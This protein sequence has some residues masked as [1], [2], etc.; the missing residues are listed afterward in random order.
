MEQISMGFVG[1]PIA[2]FWSR[3]CARGGSVDRGGLASP[4][5]R[6]AAIMSNRARFLWAW[7]LATLLATSAA[8]NPFVRM[9][10]NV[11]QGPRARNAVFIE[12]FDDRPLTRDNFLQYVNGGHYDG[13]LMH[14]LSR[15]F[16]LQ[17]GGFYPVL[18]SEP[19][20]VNVSLDPT[21]EVDLDGNPGTPNPTVI[22]EFGN[23]PF[24][25]NVRGT[26]AMAKSPGNPD[27]A[28]SEYFFNINNNG[29]T[30]P[31]G[32]DFQNGGFTVFAQV[33]GDGMNFIDA[34]NA[35]NIV[36]LNPDINNDGVRD[37]G[38]FSNPFNPVNDGVPLAGSTLVVL[39]D[40][41]RIDYLK[42]GSTTNIPAS[43]L[44]I[45]SRDMFI[46]TDAVLTGTGAITIGTGRRLGVRESFSLGRNVVNH[47]SLEP[48]MQLGSI[49]VQDYEQSAS[50]TLRL[51]IG[52][53][54]AGTQFDRL[55]VSGTAQL[56]GT[57]DVELFT[58]AGTQPGTTFTLLTAANITGGF[59]DINLPLLPAGAVWDLNTSAT[60]V[61][62][63]VAAA[64]Y[65]QD[66]TVNAAD[67]TVWRNTRGMT[68][69][70][71]GGADGNGDTVINRADYLVWKNNYGNTRGSA[72]GAGSAIGTAVPEPP[73]ALLAMVVAGIFGLMRYRR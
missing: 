61:T 13:S 59:S 36:N 15:N 30:S 35:V 2:E 31:D 73:A 57:L 24:R 33:A 50:G 51:Q 44:T 34:V 21:A 12:L 19:P 26:L 52:Q 63:S 58:A 49:T 3:I 16:V 66:G 17:G 45:A 20:P 4:Q 10:F 9:D 72:E 22:N 65:N 18:Q 67:Y 40:A 68:V 28:S 54:A 62:L 7:P 42:A 37:G 27:S 47:G 53:I 70:A 43:G 5:R 46:D 1:H 55:V 8:A 14:R 11:V 48:G 56:N 69:A 38:P 41:E 71:Y 6:P 23:T 32:L 29:G 25:S 39:L 64:D 60:D